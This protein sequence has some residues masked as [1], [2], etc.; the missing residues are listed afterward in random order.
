MGDYW[1]L[2]GWS[3]S[4]SGVDGIGD[5]NAVKLIIKFGMLII[6]TFFLSGKSY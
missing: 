2:Y 5:V 4:F 1:L 6:S 3:F